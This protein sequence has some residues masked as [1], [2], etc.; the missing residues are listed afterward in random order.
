MKWLIFNRNV[1]VPNLKK[2]VFSW[3]GWKLTR[4]WECFVDSRISIVQLFQ[5]SNFSSWPEEMR[6][7]LN[8]PAKKKI[9]SWEHAYSRIVS[10]WRIVCIAKNKRC[11]K[12]PLLAGTRCVYFGIKGI[13]N[14][15]FF[16]PSWTTC[17][18]DWFEVSK[19]KH[20]HSEKMPRENGLWCALCLKYWLED[21]SYGN[22]QPYLF[23][24]SFW[25]II[26]SFTP[27]LVLCVFVSRK[28]Q[29]NIQWIS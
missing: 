13:V 3:K 10:H 25:F 20:I 18:F 29:K 27:Q 5:L 4:W 19:K 6:F 1:A 23:S 2:W 16:S 15:F 8:F 28:I 14:L 7:Q 17:C 26:V 22:L 21:S 11:R 9:S 24:M 12:R